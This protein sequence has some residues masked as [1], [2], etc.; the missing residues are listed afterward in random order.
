MLPFQ[1]VFNERLLTVIHSVYTGY[2]IAKPQLLKYVI[3]FGWIY[4]IN[5]VSYSFEAVLTNEFYNKVLPCAPG[6]TVPNGPGYDNPTYQGCAFTGAQ[7]GSLNTPGS[8]YLSVA[9]EYSRSHLWQNWGV[10]IAFAVL[11]IL[12]TAVATELFDFTSGGGGALEYKRSKAAKQKA[13]A[14]AA[15]TDEEK[16]V[17][18]EPS[19]GSSGS[20]ETLGGPEERRS[21]KIFRDLKAFLRGR[22]LNI[23]FLTWAVSASS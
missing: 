20:S 14:S 7:M 13:K 8:K 5:P 1:S 15:P 21:Y 10:V 16:G 11:Y 23:Q 22:I 3:W 19:N 2:V 6:E 9:Y 17:K 12:I 18:A 4:Y